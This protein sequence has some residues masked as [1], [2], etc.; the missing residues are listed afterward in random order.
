MK[1]RSVAI[2]LIAAMLGSSAM[3]ANITN[4]D[5]EA[6]TVTVIVGEEQ[7]EYTIPPGQWIDL[8]EVCAGGCA[9]VLPNGQDYQLTADDV[10]SIESG[11]LL[12]DPPS[13]GA[14]LMEEQRED[15]E[16]L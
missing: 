5:E 15:T 9:V 12:F 8:S 14:D 2:A 13:Q 3:A 11:E 16:P 4:L 1:P 7:I 6:H 10:A